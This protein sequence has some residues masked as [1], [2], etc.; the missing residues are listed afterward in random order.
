MRPALSRAFAL[1]DTQLLQFSAWRRRRMRGIRAALFLIIGIGF[2]TGVLHN[3]LIFQ[4]DA[5]LIP[6]LVVLELGVVAPIMLAAAAVSVIEAPRLLTQ[7]VQ[8][9]AVV[10]AVFA[11]MTLRY[12]ALDTGMRYPAQMSGIVLIAIAM[13]G[14]F[15]WRRIA[16]TTLAF[17]IAAV[18]LEY[19]M[20]R[21]ESAPLLQAY[22]SIYMAA[23]A[24]IGAL[25]HEILMRYNWLELSRVREAQTALRET[26]GRFNAFMDNNPA[27]S[28][29]KDEDGRY[30]YANRAFRDFLGV[31]DANWQGK[32][33]FDYF[34]KDF[35][36]KSRERDL[37]ALAA[38]V[39]TQT[40]GVARDATGAGRHWLLARFA[41]TDSNGQRYIG[42]VATDLT[43]RKRIEEIARLQALTDDLTGLYNRR[44][45]SLLA[46][47][48][49]K[50]AKRL[51]LRCALL[52]VDLDRLKKIN[53]DF[54]HAGGDAALIA[55]SEALRVAVRRSDIVARIGGDE[56]IIFAAGCDDLP[57]LQN[58][59]S[60][61][62]TSYS[63]GETVP[64]ELS[65]TIGVSEFDSAD[66]VSL[67]RQMLLADKEMFARKGRKR[68]VPTTGVH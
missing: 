41:L 44:G 49:L 24:L 38:N 27:I 17:G 30:V 14:G 53:Q 57:L 20:A 26:E 18:T 13:F 65:V 67:E 43:E 35:A 51:K 10:T 25:T 21:P 31:K 58:R 8:S 19:V 60:D 6:L 61:S 9:V 50:L 68:E 37:E 23:I 3:E 36:E 47:Q 7:A 32:T 11:T 29:M 45:F 28:W 52:Y 16:F 5:T 15:S 55:V 4:A 63:H 22:S 33:D 64:F 66:D 40:E 59:L 12:F 42:G 1:T 56:F 48:E 46:E 34:P 39:A 54:G 62:V 2:A